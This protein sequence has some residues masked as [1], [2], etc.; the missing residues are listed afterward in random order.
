M[1]G[2]SDDCS[3][4]AYP[5]YN[6]ASSEVSLTKAQSNMMIRSLESVL[7]A[8]GKITRLSVCPSGPSGF[9]FTAPTKRGKDQKGKAARD[10]TDGGIE[11]GE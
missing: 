6:R 8:K 2:L 7:S 10:F 11:P 1:W 5:K 4:Y 9:C 3:I